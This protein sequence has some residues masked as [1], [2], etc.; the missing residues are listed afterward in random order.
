VAH[1]RAYHYRFVRKAACLKRAA[2]Q[3]GFTGGT[4]PSR[5]GWTLNYDTFN[6][7]PTPWVSPVNSPSWSKAADG[8]SPRNYPSLAA[9]PASWGLG[10]GLALMLGGDEVAKQVGLRMF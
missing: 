2:L 3:S 4:C 6:N 7:T 8:P 9:V 5:D 10:S 1:P